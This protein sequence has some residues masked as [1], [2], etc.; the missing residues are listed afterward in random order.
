MATPKKA[1]RRH[2]A[3]RPHARKPTFIHPPNPAKVT[4]VEKSELLPAVRQL[5]TPR[6]LDEVL[7]ARK[8]PYR[9]RILRVEIVAI[10]LIDFVLHGPPSLMALV[11]R[12]RRGEVACSTSVIKPRHRCQ[13]GSV[14]QAA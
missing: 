5:F 4:E 2:R 7:A 1:Q 8:E 9:D 11:K 14:L 13:P 12:L 3:R 10:A 6:F